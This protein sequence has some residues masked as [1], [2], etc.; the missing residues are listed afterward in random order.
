MCTTPFTSCQPCACIVLP[1][2]F[3][4][5]LCTL[6]PHCCIS[7]QGCILFPLS[8]CEREWEREWE[9]EG[10]GK[11]GRFWGCW[12]RRHTGVLPL[13]EFIFTGMLIIR[14]VGGYETSRPPPPASTLWPFLCLLIWLAKRSSGPIVTVTNGLLEASLFIATIHNTTL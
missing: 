8:V 11:G 9:G 1:F 3:N 6:S 10:G 14:Y 2:V 13:I 5:W 12:R 7:I 4:A